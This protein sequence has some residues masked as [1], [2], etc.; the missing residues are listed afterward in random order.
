MDVSR[1]ALPTSNAEY[2][3]NVGDTVKI[4][5]YK[6]ETL[7]G[8]YNVGPDGMITMPVVDRV[9]A[10]GRTALQVAEEVRASLAG[11]FLVAPQVSAEVAAYRPIYVLGEVNMPGRYDYVLGLTVLG[12]VASA[13]GF[14]YRADEK[15]VFIKSPEEPGETE[16][17]TTPDLQV[18]P[19]EIVRVEA[20][21]F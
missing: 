21:S 3:L 4:T 1:T 9:K 14:S 7:S 15:R 12:A 6:E 10:E 17:R 13:G 16:Y 5:V 20:R 2:L 19:G 8:E 11:G 18:R